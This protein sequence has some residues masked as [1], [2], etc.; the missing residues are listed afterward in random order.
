MQADPI[1]R[2]DFAESSDLH[3][4]VNH[5]PESCAREGGQSDVAF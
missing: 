4:V 5:F 1:Y 2:L 3:F